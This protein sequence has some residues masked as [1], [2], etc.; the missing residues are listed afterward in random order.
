MIGLDIFT[1]MAKVVFDVEDDS[2]LCVSV[3]LIDFVC[4]YKCFV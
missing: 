2:L 4:S 1:E 3:S